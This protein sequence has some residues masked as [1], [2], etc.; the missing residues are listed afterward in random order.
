MLDFFRFWRYNKG[1]AA[2]MRA[3][4]VGIVRKWENRA[5]QTEY[6]AAEGVLKL[7]IRRNICHDEYEQQK[8]K[9][10]PVWR[11]R[12]SS[13]SGYGRSHGAQHGHIAGEIPEDVAVPLSIL[14]FCDDTCN[15]R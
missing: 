11:N 15:L 8:D 10:D 9:A 14:R 12:R 4:A 2:E 6:G 5:P 13:G 3:E 7:Q 1:Q